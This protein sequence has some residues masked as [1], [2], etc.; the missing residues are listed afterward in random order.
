MK[1]ENVL[2]LW[3]RRGYLQKAEVESLGSPRWIK[4]VPDGLCNGGLTED[5]TSFHWSP[6][7][8]AFAW[9]RVMGGA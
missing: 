2:L 1:Y 6:Y 9:I 3:D 8:G 5:W 7:R 4:L